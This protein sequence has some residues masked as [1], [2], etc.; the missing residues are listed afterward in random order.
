VSIVY[1]RVRHRHP[2]NIARH[3]EASFGQRAADQVTGLMGSWRFIGYQTVMI[4][5]WIL[6]NTLHGWAHWDSYPFVLLNL[7]FSVQAAYASPLILLAQNRQ[8]EHDRAKA[9]HDY[10]TNSQALALLRHIA[11]RQGIE[12][13]EIGQILAAATESP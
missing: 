5:A 10:L 7:L 1:G 2:A 3:D 4:I 9:E 13:A 11:A 8:T 12:E 6:A